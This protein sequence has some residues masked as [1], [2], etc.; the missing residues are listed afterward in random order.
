MKQLNATIPVFWDRGNDT[1]IEDN[2]RAATK[3]GF[4]SSV[5]QQEGITPEK[6][7]MVKA[8]GIE[9]GAWTVNDVAMMRRLLDAGVERL[10]TDHPRLLLSLKA[11]RIKIETQKQLKGRER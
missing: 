5:L 3:H 4:E 9:V 8:A 10:Y 6:I 2:V 11:E 7:E 1:N